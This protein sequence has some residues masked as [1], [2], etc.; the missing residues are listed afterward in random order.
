MTCD[1]GD[2]PDM[3]VRIVIGSDEHPQAVNSLTVDRAKPAVLPL[4]IDA[5]FTFAQ[6]SIEGQPDELIID[7]DVDYG[8]PR[9]IF[10]DPDAD[11]VGDETS[12]RIIDFDPRVA[13]LREQ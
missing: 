4:S 13:D 9:S 2:L 1:C 11:R 10:L 12:V 3:P 8:F 6:A 7:Y 5:V